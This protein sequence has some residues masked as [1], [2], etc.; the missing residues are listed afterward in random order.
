MVYYFSFL[1]FLA[2]LILCIC[3][4]SIYKG[5]FF[6]FYSTIL[7]YISFSSELSFSLS[8]Y[9][10]VLRLWSAEELPGDM[11]AIMITFDLS[12]LAVKESL[13]MRV[14]LEALKGTWSA[15]SSMALMHYFN[16]SR[17]NDL[18]CTFC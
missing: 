7:L 1:I 13:R 10:K 6:L 2:E 16:A 5:S 3:S 17:L 4:F 9:L 12:A 11:Q 18:R 14:S 8:A 15:L